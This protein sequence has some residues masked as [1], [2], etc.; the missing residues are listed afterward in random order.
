MRKRE[1]A[2]CESRL[3]TTDAASGREGWGGEGGRVQ[4]ED[5]ARIERARG[6]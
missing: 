1:R 3:S 6:L 4:R 5:G 2:E